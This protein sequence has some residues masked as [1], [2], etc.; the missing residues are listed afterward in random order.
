MSTISAFAVY[1]SRPGK[2]Q[3]KRGKG[4]MAADRHLAKL[5]V[6]ALSPEQQEKLRQF[7]VG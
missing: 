3:T 1:K 4:R 2:N 5:D 6:G 7:K